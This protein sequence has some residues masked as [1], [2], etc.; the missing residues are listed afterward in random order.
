MARR[1]DEQAKREKLRGYW[2][3]EKVESG[4]CKVY[5]WRRQMYDV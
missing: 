4:R 1:E 2:E 3:S 5:N